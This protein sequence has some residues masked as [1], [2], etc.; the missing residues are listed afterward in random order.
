MRPWLLGSMALVICCLLGGCL[1]ARAFQCDE[2]ATCGPGAR[3]EP[4]GYC[5]VVD[6]TCDSGWRYADSAGANAGTCVGGSIVDAGADAGP[7]AGDGGSLC[8]LDPDAGA[9]APR[10]ECVAGPPIAACSNGCTAA[11]CAADP[12][13]CSTQWTERCVQL[14]E[15]DDSACPGRSCS[16][17]LTMAGYDVPIAAVHDPES[18]EW[19]E[20]WHWST[21]DGYVASLDWADYDGDGD[22]DLVIATDCGLRVFRTDP[23]FEGH[24]SMTSVWEWA[25]IEQD[26][27]CP[28][29]H[30]EKFLGRSARWIDWNGDGALDLV[31]AGVGGVVRAAY[32]PA[33]QGFVPGEVLVADGVPRPDAADVDVADVNRDGRMDL[34]IGLGAAARLYLQ[35]D[36]GGFELDTWEGT[37]FAIGAVWC[38]LGGNSDPEL[39]IFGYD[40]LTLAVYANTAGQLSGSPY[41]FLDDPGYLVIDVECG[42]LDGDGQAELVAA[43]NHEPPADPGRLRIYSS[44]D[45][46]LLWE[47]EQ[48]YSA[49]GVDLG[50]FDGDGDL[51]IALADAPASEISPEPFHIFENQSDTAELSFVDRVGADFNGIGDLGHLEWTYQPL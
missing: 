31:L 35:D 41:I 27:H 40:R 36:A 24:L 25:P 6:S 14:A 23:P 51:D 18:G 9:V 15:L 48:R 50:D 45:G 33:K 49:N 12:S 3:C 21:F 43:T 39:A 1:P 34:A 13:C 7:D 17:V 11:V 29:N 20:A 22:A 37:S 38:E 26:G 5:S 30:P 42:D 46:R 4:D 2:Q 44:A 19:S 28:D 16:N 32:D 8:P 47:S 10:S